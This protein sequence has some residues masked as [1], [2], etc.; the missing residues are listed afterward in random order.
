MKLHT[1]KNLDFKVCI[2]GSDILFPM[3]FDSLMMLLFIKMVKTLIKAF[4]N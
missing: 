4:Q 1:K 2:T 3:M